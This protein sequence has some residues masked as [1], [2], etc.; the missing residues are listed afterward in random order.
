MTA[1]EIMGS[2]PEKHEA[3]IEAIKPKPHKTVKIG[4]QIIFA[5]GATSGN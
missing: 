4:V 2:T 1:F 5:R 3:K